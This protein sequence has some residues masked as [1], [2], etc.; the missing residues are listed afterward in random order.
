MGRKGQ[1]AAGG[2]S[3]CPECRRRSTPTVPA[4]VSS[5]IPYQPLRWPRSRHFDDRS[6]AGAFTGVPLR[7]R[8]SW[9]SGLGYAEVPIG[10]PADQAL[11]TLLLELVRAWQ[12][13]TKIW[14]LWLEAKSAISPL[15]AAPILTV[16]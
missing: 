13:E 12:E 11:A 14:H 16:A 9:Q 4:Y 2:S 1:F 7:S 8:A 5:N 6:V 15:K 10:G 3:R